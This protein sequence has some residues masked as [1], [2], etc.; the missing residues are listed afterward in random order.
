MLRKGDCMFVS[1][2]LRTR[3][4]FSDEGERHFTTAIYAREFVYLGERKPD[5][6]INLK[7]TEGTNRILAMDQIRTILNV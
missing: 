3:E 5:E 6:T 7:A 1:G 4:W 2:E